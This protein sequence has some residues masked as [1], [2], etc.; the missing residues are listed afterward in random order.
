MPTLSVAVSGQPGEPDLANASQ[1][2]TQ[3]KGGMAMARMT[4]DPTFYPSPRSAMAAP[5][6]ELAYVVTVNPEGTR[7]DALSVL[8]VD[9]GSSGYGRVVGRLDMPNVGDELHH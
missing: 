5:P 7:P 2:P 1:I 6:E 4:P 3:R 8:D 9:P